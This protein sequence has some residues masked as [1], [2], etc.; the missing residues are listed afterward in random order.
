[1]TEREPSRVFL[2]G[3]HIFSRSRT[4]SNVGWQEM[5][6]PKE[7]CATFVSLDNV[8]TERTASEAKPQVLRTLHK[9]PVIRD[10][11]FS[12]QRK[13]RTKLNIWHIVEC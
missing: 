11:K 9:P 4:N 5:G 2:R 3:Q 10:V 8:L 7:H 1:M 12:F 6:G 13:I